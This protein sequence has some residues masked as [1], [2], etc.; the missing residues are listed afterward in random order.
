M[1]GKKIKLG[2][3]IPHVGTIKAQT[4]FS[5]FAALKDFPHDYNVFMKEGCILHANRQEIV[6]KAI[7]KECTH[8]LFV[9]SDMSFPKDAVVRLLARNKDIVG[10]HYNRRKFPPTST[11][12]NPKDP[13]MGITTCDSVATGFM[14]IKL[15][16]FKKLSKPWFFWELDEKGK[17]VTGEDYFFCRKA[18]E[19]GYE[20]W[21]DFTL[22]VLH[23]G[24]HFY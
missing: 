24:S 21:A 13:N 10:A 22:E 9:D 1:T 11:V 6:E 18:R 2:I 4:A 8:L 5:L 20:I 14:L 23:E 3:G 12:V 15:D 17:T 7:E 19:A 16:V